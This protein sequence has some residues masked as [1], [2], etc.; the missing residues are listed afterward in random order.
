V[1]GKETTM[2]M[3]RALIGI[4]LATI[5][6]PG[7]AAATEAEDKQAVQQVYAKYLQSVNSADVALAEQIW[8][9]S[10]DLVVV[11]PFGRFQGWNSVRNDIY[12]NFLQKGFSERKLEGTN[13]AVRVSG[14]TA[15]L[16]YDWTFTG[17]LSNGQTLSSKGWET[18]VY[19]RVGRNWRISHL[20][21]SSP[22]PRP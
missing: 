11:T 16:V 20:H 21:Y 4:V 14:N 13:V 18:H 2:T 15:W 17:T 10:A 5:L 12:I 1:R 8:S 3:R 19:E 6:G 9:H 7:A 22:P